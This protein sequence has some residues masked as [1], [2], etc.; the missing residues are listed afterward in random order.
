MVR[1]QRRREIAG[2]FNHN[3]QTP[4]NKCRH[5]QTVSEEMRW[6]RAIITRPIITFY[7]V[8]LIAFWVAGI[9]QNDVIQ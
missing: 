8:T 5:S 2:R 7:V 3:L 6:L 4:L 1:W 9:W